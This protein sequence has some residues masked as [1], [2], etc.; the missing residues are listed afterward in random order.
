M[1][2][3]APKT[4]RSAACW[5]CTVLRCKENWK[6]KYTGDQ[7]W[8]WGWW[9]VASTRNRIQR[10][11]RGHLVH[12]P[13]P[14]QP[15]KGCTEETPRNTLQVFSHKELSFPQWACSKGIQLCLPK[16]PG[17]MHKNESLWGEEAATLPLLI[18]PICIRSA[19]GSA[20]N[21]TGDR[22]EPQL[23]PQSWR[24]DQVRQADEMT[25]TKNHRIT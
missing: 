12:L 5:V 1:T 22:V 8:P 23:W 7:R 17:C 15:C 2:R 13:S 3:C 4:P 6:Q 16:I 20:S 11:R 21:N 19:I 18:Q 24:K 25:N 14:G 9:T 10:S